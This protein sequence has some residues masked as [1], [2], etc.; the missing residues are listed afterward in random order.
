MQH[1]VQRPNGHELVDDDQGGGVA[2]T[3]NHGQDVGV[4]ENPQA[5]VFL[6]E[7]ARDAGDHVADIE[8]LRHNIVL[9]PATAPCL[10]EQNVAGYII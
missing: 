1:R 3:A 8:D 4:G 9:L 5:G 6:V 10:W 2:A 7:V